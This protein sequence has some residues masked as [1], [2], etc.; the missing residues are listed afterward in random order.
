MSLLVCPLCGKSTSLR[1]FDPS[2]FGD[3]I[4]VRNVRGLG[5]GRGF[6]VTDEHSIIDDEEI[7]RLIVARALR[8]VAMIRRRGHITPEEI[9]NALDIETIRS[10]TLRLHEHSL[11]QMT[12]NRDMWRQRTADL[13][14]ANTKL[15]RTGK[16]REEKHSRKISELER[17]VLLA[18]VFFLVALKKVNLDVIL[19]P[20]REVLRSDQMQ[21]AVTLIQGR[22]PQ[23]EGPLRYVDV[24]RV[25]RLNDGTS[26]NLAALY[27]VIRRLNPE[28]LEVLVRL[29]RQNAGLMQ[30]I[31]DMR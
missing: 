9:L 3:D 6:E 10:E 23:G 5:R 8:I 14:E 25:A 29:I 30:L 2:D 12:T 4:V 24:L 28:H 20:L 19:I 27:D 15:E 18:K 1:T 13:V 11:R 22:I 26:V 31:T 17:Q 16:E 7:T 21:T